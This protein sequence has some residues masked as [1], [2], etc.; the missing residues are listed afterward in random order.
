MRTL[1]TTSLGAFQPRKLLTVRGSVGPISMTG[2]WAAFAV[3]TQAGDQL[4]PL[5][6]WSVYGVEI[7]SGRAVVLAKD[8]TATELSELP[9]PS[10]GD[11]FIVWDEMMNG[12]N[13]VLMRYDVNS[14][15]ITQLKLPAGTYPVYASAS[16]GAVGG[17]NSIRRYR[18]PCHDART[19]QPLPPHTGQALS[20][21]A[22]PCGREPAPAAAP[23]TLARQLTP[24]PSA[25]RQAGWRRPEGQVVQPAEP[26]P[27]C[28]RCET[29]ETG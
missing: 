10:A 25:R 4:S 8:T 19:N 1:Y 24:T 7:T 29:T 12:G 23:L 27:V 21:T 13:K 18:R 28:P 5:A 15:A 14:G 6:A 2:S 26:V 9:F 11:G 22:R 20:Q 3:Y 16:G 17:Q